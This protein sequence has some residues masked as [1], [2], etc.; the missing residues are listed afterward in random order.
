MNFSFQNLIFIKT[1]RKTMVKDRLAKIAVNDIMMT[2]EI[3]YLT[4]KKFIIKT[5]DVK[6]MLMKNIEE[7]MILISNNIIV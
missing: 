1:Q 2:I 3:E 5:I 6:L 7:K 4:I